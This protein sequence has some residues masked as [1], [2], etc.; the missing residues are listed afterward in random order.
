MISTLIFGK[1]GSAEYEI[2]KFAMGPGVF[3]INEPV[4]FGY[5]LVLNAFLAIPLFLIMPIL[6]FTTYMGIA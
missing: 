6:V 4:T 2:S 5:P 1:R 3:N